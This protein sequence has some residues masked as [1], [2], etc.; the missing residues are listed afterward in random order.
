MQATYIR[1]WIYCWHFFCL[2]AIFSCQKKGSK[3]SISTN[4]NTVIIPKTPYFPD[5]ALYDDFPKLKRFMKWWRG[6]TNHIAGKA[7]T[8][9]KKLIFEAWHKWKGLTFWSH[10]VF[11]FFLYLLISAADQLCQIIKAKLGSYISFF[12]ISLYNTIQIILIYFPE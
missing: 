4:H 6:D 9:A 1:F 5:L 11:K 7:Q 3:S 8:Y 2:F 10:P 12:E